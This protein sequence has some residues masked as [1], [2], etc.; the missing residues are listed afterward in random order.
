[1]N[2]RAMI[3]LIRAA[4]KDFLKRLAFSLG[5]LMKGDKLKE[6][7]RLA[8]QNLG[9]DSII[10]GLNTKMLK[11]QKEVRHDPDMRMA[12]SLLCD[13]LRNDGNGGRYI[14][15]DLCRRGSLRMHDR[16]FK[17][18][19][20]D[21]SF[22]LPNSNYPIEVVMIAKDV[23]ERE[24]WKLFPILID[25]LG[26]NPG[27]EKEIDHLKSGIHTPGCPLLWHL[28]QKVTVNNAQPVNA[29]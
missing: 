6:L 20:D 5:S 11:A 25:A 4:N 2:N 28:A 3:P 14:L 10:F 9:F 17:A 12:W 7:Y 29:R 24:D 18:V 26:E 13:T 21:C 23:W 8:K 27:Y 15:E 16:M 1:M 22:E 19:F